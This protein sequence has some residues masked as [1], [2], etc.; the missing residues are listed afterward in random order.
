[1]GK[2]HKTVQC[3]K[4]FTLN[5]EDSLYCSKCGSV[6]EG[7]HETLTHI[8][9]KEPQKKETI[10]FSPGDSFSDRYRIIEEIGRGGMG[11]VYKAEDK[12][13]GISVALKMIRPEYSS[14]PSFIKRFKKET[15]LARSISHENVIRIHDLG[16]IDEI[17]YISMEYIKGQNL[18]ELIR[19]SGTLTVETTISIIRQICEALKV[20]HQKGIVHRDLKPQNI[21][22]DNNGIVYAMDFGLAKSFEAQETSISRAIVGT[23]PY[24]SPEQA[25]GEKADQRSDIYS[26]GIIMYELLTGK[27]PFEAET[28]AGYIHKHIHERPAAP[29][30]INPLIPFYLKRIIIKCL[31]KDKEQRYKN[32]EE[33]LEDLEVQKVKSRQF[34]SRT[35]IRKLLKVAFAPALILIIALGAYL[36]IVRKKPEVP[37]PAEGGKISVAVIYFENNTGD[38]SLDYLR[39]TLSDLMIYDLSQSK[40]IIVLAG[41]RLFDILRQLNLLEAK[42]YS[43]EDL[44]HI[45]ERGGVNHILVGDYSKWGD[46]FRI[47][48][49]LHEVSTGKI[50]G[51]ES[52]QG[53]GDKIMLSMIDELTRR[54]KTNFK[55]SDEMIAA[56]IDKEVE[57]I[58]TSSP[59][60]LKHYSEGIRYYNE[61]KFEE[62]IKVL[63]KA[64]AVDPE[65]AMAHRLIATDYAYLGQLDKV[66]E[67]LLKALTQQNH[68]S[69]RE[70]YLIQ[71]AYLNMVEESYTEAI[72]ICQELL[73][74]YPEDEE[75][76]IALGAIYRNQE[77]WDLSLERFDKVLESNKKSH[78]AFENLAYMYMAK[79]LY[80]K[81]GEIL[82]ANQD[83]FSNQ[84]LYHRFMSYVYLCQSRFDLALH[85]ADRAN[86]VEPENDEYIVLK[87]EIY[88]LKGDLLSAKKVYKELLEKKEPF[89]QSLGQFWMSHLDLMQGQYN[90]CK[91]EIIQG[92]EHSRKYDLE[93]Y[94]LN[95][96]LLL[97][98]LNLKINHFPEALDA[99]NQATEIALKTNSTDNQKNA[100]HF[101]G[102]T[103]LK[104]K[105]IKKAKNTAEKLKKLIERSGIRKHMRHYYHLMGMIALDNNKVSQSKDFFKKAFSLLSFQI[106]TLKD[107]SFYVDSLASTQYKLG[108]IEK[109]REHYELIASLTIG[110]L[111]W[112]DI[113]AKSFYWLG[114]IYQMKDR[115]IKAIDHYEKFLKLWKDADSGIPEAADAKKQLAI[116]KKTSHG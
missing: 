14:K 70:R 64:V 6:L 85:E 72:K 20:A 92:I 52:V 94:E 93:L 25:K 100:L 8:P 34:L 15:L 91:K 116:L 109:A 61:R 103:Y 45:A 53:T 95:F 21:M 65:F 111:A 7:T 12:E 63:E 114:K 19:T 47:N 68:L 26:L 33:I 50:I 46:T 82:R 89:L 44:K 69:E 105:N 48:T 87:G 24:L 104:M 74:L 84:A 113:Y 102:L 22:I 83:V 76:N 4:C 39:K 36:L 98:Y 78:F 37:S 35:R 88:Y 2:Q 1:M 42:N 18:K 16:E 108:D 107:Q 31:E 9:G 67:Y 80:S 86:S 75:G 23:P 112:G 28:T 3:P 17:K 115:K 90:K 101:R 110:R 99:A 58:T 71:G 96:L 5:A 32:A 10:D 51:S 77:E 66:K 11:R 29:S 97:A 27:Q 40:Y 49:M 30:E 13:L 81:A 56:D 38:K 54:T 79:G 41:G 59:E 60:A 106:Y 43:W 57:E 55:L 73:N 62:S